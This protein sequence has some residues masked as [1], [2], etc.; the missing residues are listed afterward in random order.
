MTREEKAERIR[1]GQRAAWARG[2]RWGHH[3]KGDRDKRHQ[4]A[5]AVELGEMTVTEAAA[6]LDIHT[7]SMS[8]WMR[9]NGYKV[10]KRNSVPTERALKALRE[11]WARE[12]TL[13]DV[14]EF[15]GRNY[16]TVRRW[17]DQ[18][19]GKEIKNA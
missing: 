5:A 13:N 3:L 16:Y 1:E 7:M 19:F 15:T 12:C 18:G 9:R 17:I 10:T 14:C 6:E 4:L 2:V 11:Y 8:A